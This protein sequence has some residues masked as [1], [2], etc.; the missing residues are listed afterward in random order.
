MNPVPAEV[1]V[2]LD[3]FRGLT[4]Q[5]H[6]GHRLGRSE[7]RSIDA[8]LVSMLKHIM[9]VPPIKDYALSQH[10]LVDYC[11]RMDDQFGLKQLAS[12]H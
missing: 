6:A 4:K 1:N 11:Q 12:A 5:A 10:T 7:P 9:Y 8:V 2:V 3:Q